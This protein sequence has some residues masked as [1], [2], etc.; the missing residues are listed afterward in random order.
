VCVCVLFRGVFV[1]PLCVQGGRG[2][3]V[4]YLKGLGSSSREDAKL[5]FRDLARHKIKFA[6]EGRFSAVCA[7]FCSL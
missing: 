5:Y 7:Q 1:H 3:K 6:W 4:K 2:W